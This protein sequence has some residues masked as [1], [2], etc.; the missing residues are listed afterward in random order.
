MRL[1]RLSRLDKDYAVALCSVY[2]VQI[3]IHRVYESQAI[4]SLPQRITVP[5][6][7]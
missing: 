5:F 7:M 6:Q 3:S 2:T 1:W 4:A